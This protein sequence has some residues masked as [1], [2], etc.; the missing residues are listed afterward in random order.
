[1]DS[2]RRAAEGNDGTS[3]IASAASHVE[4]GGAQEVPVCESMRRRRVSGEGRWAVPAAL[5]DLVRAAEDRVRA[6]GYLRNVIRIVTETGL[7]IYKELTPMKKEQLDLENGT[8]WIPDSKTPNGVAEVPLTEIAA[9]AFRRQLAISG[10]RPVS[11][12]ERRESRRLSEDVQDRLARDAAAGE[13][14]DT[15][16]STIS[17]RRTPP[18]SAPAALPTSGSRS[19]SGRAMR[20]CS[21]ST[22]R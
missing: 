17:D 11:V 18:G 12:P 20:R 16:A 14:F 19:C 22:R 3:G 5:C 4:C 7:R 9:E 1:M 6:P 10:P 15:F 13:V 8:V 21:R 2:W